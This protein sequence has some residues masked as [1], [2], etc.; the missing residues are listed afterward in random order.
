MLL[1]IGEIPATKVSTDDCLFIQLTSA[2]VALFRASRAL[3]SQH[4]DA[5]PSLWLQLHAFTH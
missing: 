5:W 2:Y 3:T 4:Q 1:Q